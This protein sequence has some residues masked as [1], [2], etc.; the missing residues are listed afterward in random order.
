[1]KTDKRVG[2]VNGTKGMEE[3]AHQVDSGKMKVAFALYPVSL[4][5]LKEVADHS[6][7]MPPKSTYIKPKLR[8]GMLVY[9]LSEI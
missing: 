6:A 4:K 2:F 1:L 3:L 8:S 5:Q 7:I 9:S